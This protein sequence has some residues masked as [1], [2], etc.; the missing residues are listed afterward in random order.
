MVQVEK[1]PNLPL[2]SQ[3]LLFILRL[4]QLLQRHILTGLV[5]ID[6]DSIED[7]AE[8][9]FAQAF[10]QSETRK[11]RLP[12]QLT[13]FLR[14]LPRAKAPEVLHAR[15]SDSTFL[16]WASQTSKRASAKATIVG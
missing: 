9:A 4:L 3:L 11:S 5:A 2:K 1:S 6:L 12:L 10:Q 16:V 15:F 8:A 7:L 14:L 13:V